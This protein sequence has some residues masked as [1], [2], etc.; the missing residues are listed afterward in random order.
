MSDHNVLTECN[1]EPETCSY[2]DN[3]V[4]RHRWRLPY[5]NGDITTSGQGHK[6]SPPQQVV[7][8]VFL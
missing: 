7:A 5:W 8:A 1:A 4:A 6:V 3:V 2:Y